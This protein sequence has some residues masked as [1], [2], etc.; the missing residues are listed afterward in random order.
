MYDVTKATTYYFNFTGCSSERRSKL[1][2][3]SAILTFIASFFDWCKTSGTCTVNCCAAAS[4]SPKVIVVVVVVVTAA[5]AVTTGTVVY[6]HHQQ[7]EEIL[8]I[9]S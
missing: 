3:G 2:C 6:V 1:I 4:A 5:T 9:L 7:G 8:D